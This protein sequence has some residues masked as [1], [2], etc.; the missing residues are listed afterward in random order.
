M[1]VEA[2]SYPYGEPCL[3]GLIKSRNDD[4]RVDEELGFEPSG[5]GEHWLLQVEKDGL[6]TAQ[7]IARLAADFGLHPRQIGCSGLKDKNAVATQWLSL[8]LPGKPLPEARHSS[9]AY[10]VLRAER[11]R[12][13]LRR[14][15]HR[16]NRFRVRVR[17]IDGLPDATLRQLDDVERHGM[18]NYFGAQRFGRRG[19]NVEQALV[20]LDRSRLG[21]QQKSLLIS[22]LR[23]E[24]FNRVL[25]LRIVED[26]WRAPVDGDVFM[27]RGSRSI[28]S[29][30]LD[31][32]IRR[33]YDSLD[34]SATG[35]LYGSGDNRLDG[36]AL[37][38]ERRVFDANREICECLERQD[39]RL[40]MRALR[41]AVED[42]EYRLDKTEK[43][44]EVTATLPAGSYLTSLLGHFVNAF[45]DDQADLR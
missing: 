2:L 21:R 38:L 43:L 13:K 14:G 45:E 41:V 9:N 35:S 11:H 25:A 39:A 42:F 15:T 44:L 32:E 29:A 6:T 16:S 19:D 36:E 1:N 12:A 17:G 18:A 4:F 31:D 40:Q 33:R 8:H 20:R 5:E 26:C 3:K 7:L 34:I 23:S 37:R 30:P 27:L 28:F 24:L 22:A 10:R